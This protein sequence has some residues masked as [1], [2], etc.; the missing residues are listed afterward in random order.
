MF[1]K[2]DEQ[3]K[4]HKAQHPNLEVHSEVRSAQTNIIWRNSKHEIWLE[5][6]CRHRQWNV[7]HEKTS[8]PSLSWDVFGCEDWKLKFTSQR[9][10][11]IASITFEKNELKWIELNLTTGFLQKTQQMKLFGMLFGYAVRESF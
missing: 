2:P 5:G 10:N 4:I 7:G 11:N 8:S 1:D 6:I 9:A 3:T